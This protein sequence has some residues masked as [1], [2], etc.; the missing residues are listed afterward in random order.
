M[1]PL[2]TVH[3]VLVEKGSHDHS[4]YLKL[5]SD[6]ICMLVTC[7]AQCRPWSCLLYWFLYGP[8]Q[9]LLYAFNSFMSTN[10]PLASFPGARKIGR[11]LLSTFRAPRI[12][13]KLTLTSMLNFEYHGNWNRG[14]YSSTYFCSEAHSYLYNSTVTICNLTTALQLSH[15]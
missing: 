8:F 2:L 4:E 12:E 11:E 6:C 10:Q 5:F 15:Y 3:K 14:L 9:G 13:A 7:C 1:Y